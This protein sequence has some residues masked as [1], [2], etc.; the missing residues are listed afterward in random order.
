MD[1]Q[2]I[3]LTIYYLHK[4]GIMITLYFINFSDIAYIGITLYNSIRN[5]EKQ[6]KKSRSFHS[7]ENSKRNGST[8]NIKF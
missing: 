7:L 3:M 2:Y 4:N 8:K 6:N 1:C 5:K